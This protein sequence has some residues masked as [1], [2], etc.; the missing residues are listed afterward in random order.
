M[1]LTSL[2]QSHR[3]ILLEIRTLVGSYGMV[4]GYGFINGGLTDNIS[5][6]LIVVNRSR[7]GVIKD[8][9]AGEDLDSYEDEN[10]TLALRWRTKIILLYTR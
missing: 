10:Y 1:Q 3:K 5:A 7:D 2:P 8:L 4:E 9:G 6:R